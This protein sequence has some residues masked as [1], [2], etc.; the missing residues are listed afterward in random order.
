MATV[1]YQP[2][3]IQL[4]VD[5]SHAM[6]ETK[7]SYTKG[8]YYCS[9][10]TYMTDDGNIVK[11]YEI[12][13]DTQYGYKATLLVC[14]DVCLNGPYARI[15]TVQG[16]KMM[17]RTPK[18]PKHH[19]ML[20]NGFKCMIGNKPAILV[21]HNSKFV[22]LDSDG[23]SDI[24]QHTPPAKHV[25]YRRPIS[26]CPPTSSHHAMD[27]IDL[28]YCPDTGKTPLGEIRMIDISDLGD[29]PWRT[30]ST[31]LCK[32]ACCEMLTCQG[33]AQLV[34][35]DADMLFEL[36]IKIR[37]VDIDIS[38][39]INFDM[40]RECIRL[41]NLNAQFDRNFNTDLKLPLV[42][43]VSFRSRPS[44]VI[45]ESI[46]NTPNFADRRDSRIAK[47]Q[48]E[49]HIHHDA[50]YIQ[51]CTATTQKELT[52][53]SRLLRDSSVHHDFVDMCGEMMDGKIH[54]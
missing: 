33:I 1:E 3:A 11:G 21:R 51:L 2:K 34:C 29:G 46:Y 15:F 48:G 23:R 5:L 41:E 26:E 9:E 7:F 52:S 6:R 19:F 40:K 38:Q 8:I 36:L 49:S 4:S 18:A 20:L 28:F 27:S 10:M 53:L 44:R 37:R 31:A 22:Q 13:V 42:F 50:K 35:S 43:K 47:L 16:E 24:D 45:D 54:K 12:A 25:A 17:M 14:Q 30:T 39:S 32:V